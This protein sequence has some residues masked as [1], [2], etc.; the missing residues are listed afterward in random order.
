MSLDIRRQ[1]FNPFFTTRRDQ[2]SIGLGLHIVH[3]IVTN[4]LGGVI[5]L[6]SED[7]EAQRS[8]FW[9]RARRRLNRSLRRLDFRL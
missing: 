1:A 6:E 9:C 7:G 5:H 2:G 8:G 4:C 3:N